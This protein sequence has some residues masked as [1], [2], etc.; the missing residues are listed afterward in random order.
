MFTTIILM[1]TN[2]LL[3]GV[4]PESIGIFVFGLV[5]IAFA[6]FL[7]RFFGKRDEMIE[8]DLEKTVG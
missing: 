3:L 7:R 6:I 8:S 5:L 2:N 1:Q 4:M